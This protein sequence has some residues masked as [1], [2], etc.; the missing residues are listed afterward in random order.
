MAEESRS[1]M[2][3]QDFKARFL[4]ALVMTN[5]ALENSERDPSL[6]SE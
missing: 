6:R 4:A 1:V 3:R 2:G 5:V